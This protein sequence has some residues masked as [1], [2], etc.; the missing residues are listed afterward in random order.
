MRKES[1]ESL[2]AAACRSKASFR[3]ATA[4]TGVST[5]EARFLGD[6]RVEG[7]ASSFDD[8]STACTMRAPAS[9]FF[10]NETRPV[11]KTKRSGAQR[12]VASNSRARSMTTC[13]RRPVAS[14]KRASSVAKASNAERSALEAALRS[15]ATVA[16]ATGLHCAAALHALTKSSL[17]AATNNSSA[18]AGIE[19]M[20]ASPMNASA[21]KPAHF[22]TASAA[23]AQPR[24]A[25]SC[26]AT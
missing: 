18:W 22:S 13:A 15:D 11:K 8:A 2:C 24:D 6:F 25:W 4:S 17:F 12:A 20:N 16:A 26:V 14:V 10:A 1:G 5:P 7:S 3:D 21:F 19:P 23:V 9:S